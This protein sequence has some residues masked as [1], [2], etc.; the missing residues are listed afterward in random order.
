VAG[1]NSI[2]DELGALLVFPQGNKHG[3]ATANARLAFLIAE[4]RSM[5]TSK[6]LNV[7]L[8]DQANSVH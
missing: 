1:G 5:T 6:V 4:R 3:G 8:A 2:L 7:Q